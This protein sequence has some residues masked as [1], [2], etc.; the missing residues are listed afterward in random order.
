[1]KN[2]MLTPSRRARDAL[3]D[4]MRIDPSLRPLVE[5]GEWHIL[6]SNADDKGGIVYVLGMYGRCHKMT[7]ELLRSRVDGLRNYISNAASTRTIVE[8]YF[9]ENR[10]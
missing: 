4:Y 9:E 6:Q 8:A 10:P 1:M 3:T 7:V 2:R 5:Q